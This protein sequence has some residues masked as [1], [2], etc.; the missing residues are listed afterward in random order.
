[1]SNE[2]ITREAWLEA[3][4]E[5]LRPRFQTVGYLLPDQVRVSVGWAVSFR[6]E[7]SS[8]LALTVSRKIT[9]DDV[10]QI[11]VTPEEDRASDVLGYLV[12]ELT[13]VAVGTDA[14]HGPDFKTC[15]LAVG[16][17]GK[18]TQA[19]PGIVLAAELVALAETLG[20]YPHRKVD[21]ELAKTPAPVPAGS[22]VP[23]FPIPDV[24]APRW[25]SGPRTQTNRQLLVKCREAHSDPSLDGYQVRTSATWL[26]RGAPQCPD[27]HPMSRA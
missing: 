26:D 25:T 16:L 10:Y 15:A 27:G 9:K 12:H 7:N 17:D 2:H 14:G 24:P 1:M 5:T 21:L 20:D 4:I 13:H 3:A 18:M 23:A 6:G 22:N 11:Y 19:L 8:I